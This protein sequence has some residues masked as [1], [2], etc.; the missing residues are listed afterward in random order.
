MRRHQSRLTR[1]GLIAVTLGTAFALATPA[2]ADPSPAPGSD[3]AVTE[4]KRQEELAAASVAEVEGMLDSLA[5]QT[6]QAEAAAGAAAEA[7]NKAQEELGA[8]TEAAEAAQA[9][10]DQSAIDLEAARGA[11]ARLALMNAQSGSDIAQLEPLLTSGGIEEAMNK[12]A[13]LYVV[14]STTDRAAAKFALAKQAAEQDGKRAETAIKLREEKADQAAQAASAAQQAAETAIKAQA[15][16]EVRH[17]ELLQ[18]LALK[19]QITLEAAQAAEERRQREKDEEARRQ[20][21]SAQPS[22]TQPT[23]APAPAPTPAPSPAP[24]PTE[25]TVTQDPAPDQSSGAEAG[26][27]AVAWAR[28]Q[29]GKPY[30][31]GGT[32][33][34]SFD[35]SGLTSQAWLNGGGKRI[36]RVAADQYYAATKIPYDQM[37][38]GDLIFWGSDLHHVAIYSGNGN[39]IEAPSAG[40][41]IREIPIRWSGTVQYAGRVK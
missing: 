21:E 16:A 37:R 36:P 39:M 19:Q 17:Q 1:F 25:D 28:Q 23:P 18:V 7:Y 40:K 34:S 20:R 4:A 24:D 9:A 38:P 35:C 33:P 5:E 30:Q 8:A 32:G 6:A 27:A 29:I 26:L 15:E 13:L 10:A 11:L 2:L 41:N 3:A 14:G 31:W 12:S 22:P